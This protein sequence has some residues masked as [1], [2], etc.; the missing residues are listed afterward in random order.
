M[1][2]PK[3]PV[4]TDYGAPFAGT[5]QWYSGAG[6]DL[7]NS[8]TRQVTL[9]AGTA[10]LTF[11]ATLEHRGLRPRPVRL[12]VRRGRRRIRLDR[13]P[14][15]DHQAPPRATGSTAGSGGWKPATFDLTKYAGKTVGLRLRY[16]TDGAAQGSPTPTRRPASSPTR[17]S[18]P[19]ARTTVFEDGAESGNN[20]WTPDGFS[21]RRRERRRR[22]TTTTTSR[23]TGSTSRTTS[24]SRPARTTSG[25]RTRSRTGWSTSRTRTACWSTT[26]TPRSRTTTRASTRAGR[27]AADRLAPE[28]DL[29]ARRAAVAREDPDV[30]LAVLAR[31]GGLVHPARQ[32]ARRATSAGRTARAGVR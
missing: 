1:P 24:T 19:P 13:D 23:R 9:P 3:K 8:L 11:Q 15:L 22:C 25:R 20:G 14:G 17:S 12:R 7:D 27:G 16:R 26:G 21:D 2:L 4:V 18:S 29:Q 31:E 30:R 6:D 28:P 5:K 10:T 32:T